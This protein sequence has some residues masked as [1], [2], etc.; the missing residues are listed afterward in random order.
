MERVIYGPRA[1]DVKIGSAWRLSR[2]RTR[3]RSACRRTVRAGDAGI[4]V[5]DVG[6]PIDRDR[7]RRTRTV[8]DLV[9]PG[10]ASRAVTRTASGFTPLAP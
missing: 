10:M 1:P 6:K 3:G 5:P 8:R 4:G 2:R 9:I 7:P